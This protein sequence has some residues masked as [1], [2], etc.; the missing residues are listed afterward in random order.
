MG[1]LLFAAFMVRPQVQIDMVQAAQFANS[2]AGVVQPGHDHAITGGVDRVDQ[3]SSYS[4]GQEPRVTS[5]RRRWGKRI[6]GHLQTGD[7]GEEL[8]V[9]QCAGWQPG[10]SELLVQLV[11]DATRAT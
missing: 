3:R 6:R 2:Y 7:V 5:R 9:F 1:E 8:L 11:V 4:I 10:F